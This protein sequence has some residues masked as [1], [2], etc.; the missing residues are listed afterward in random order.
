L[1]IAN[2]ATW[3][4]SVNRESSIKYFT[5]TNE[6]AGNEP[7]SQSSFETIFEGPFYLRRISAEETYNCYVWHKSDF[8]RERWSQFLK[9]HRI[10]DFAHMRHQAVVLAQPANSLK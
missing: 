1:T 9:I 6:I 3:L 4:D 8:I 5:R 10:V 7:M 2:E